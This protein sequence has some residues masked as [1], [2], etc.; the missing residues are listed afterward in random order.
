MH[1]H[2]GPAGFLAAYHAGPLRYEQHL[3]AGKALPSETTA[4]VAAVTPFLNNEQGEHAA[5]GGRRALPW[6]EASLFVERA[7]AP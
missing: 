7:G 4:Y 6:R 3:V 1:D 2:F 5:T